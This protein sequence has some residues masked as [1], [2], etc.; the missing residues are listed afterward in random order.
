[1]ALDD[2]NN[3]VIISIGQDMSKQKALEVNAK[4]LLESERRYSYVVEHAP[5]PILIIDHKGLIIEANPEAIL[6]AG[7]SK[8]DMIGK[9]FIELM[10]AKA[11]R[12]KAIAAA[13]RAM[14]GEDF[15]A[16]ELL[17]QNAAGDKYEYQ[18]SIGAVG[19]NSR[20]QEN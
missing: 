8:L 13:A 5:L 14:R 15:R 4:K 7:Y 2:E 17:L 1:M 19:E 3:P 16:I 11:S 9:N 18:C 12:K 10:V 6:A 20:D